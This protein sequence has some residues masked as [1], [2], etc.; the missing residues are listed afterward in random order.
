MLKL[1]KNFLLRLKDVLDSTEDVKFWSQ[2]KKLFC[3]IIHDCL[4]FFKFLF[5][6]FDKRYGISS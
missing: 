3:Q 1:L 5:D 4:F 2:N 6:F